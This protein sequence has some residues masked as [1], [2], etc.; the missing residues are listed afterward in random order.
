[1]KV[2]VI[3]GSIHKDSY[4]LQLIKHVQN[5]YA[6]QSEVEILDLAPLPMY[7]QDMELDAPQEVLVSKL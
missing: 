1:M 5:R 2:V 6:E 3:V 7:N 4:N